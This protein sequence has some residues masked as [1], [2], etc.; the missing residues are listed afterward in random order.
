[1]CGKLVS[2]ALK[3]HNMP[4][5]MLFLNKMFS[6]EIAIYL[7]EDTG[8]SL[9]HRACATCKWYPGANFEVM[10]D[11]LEK[12]LR[13]IDANTQLVS[14]QFKGYGPIHLTSN[15]NVIEL[16][17]QHGASVDLKTGDGATAIGMCAAK[18]AYDSVYLLASLGADIYAS[19][20]PISLPQFLRKNGHDSVLDQLIEI[21]HPKDGKPTSY[22]W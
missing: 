13:S 12:L 1:M 3:N 6:R 20:G 2:N 18:R 17:C 15:V 22:A 4:E 8:W 11:L 10:K 21:T 5:A 9:L 16:L 7:E 14:G 19:Y